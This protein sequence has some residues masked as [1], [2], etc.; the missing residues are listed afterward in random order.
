MAMR[1]ILL[2]ATVL[3]FGG[4][5]TT[6]VALKYAPPQNVTVVASGSESVSVGTFEDKRGEPAT[7]LGAIRGGF[8]NPLKT[9]ESNEPV[10]SVVAN[11]FAEGLRA[12]GIQ[13]TGAKYQI[14]GTIKVLECIQMVRRDA[15]VEIDVKVIATDTKKEIFAKTVKTNTLDGSI[16]NLAT[17]VFAS[18]EDLRAVTEKTLRD[19][20]DR[21]LDDPDF[22][23][24]LKSG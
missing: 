19:A 2:A 22:R 24:A 16:L 4:C 17:G 5:S 20:V 15:S 10:A 3:L 14:G 18:V 13:S 7:Y 8:G 11:A 23:K 9:L 6:G 1:L 12:R 21:A